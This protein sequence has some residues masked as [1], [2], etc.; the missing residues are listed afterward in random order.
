M[1]IQTFKHP[2]DLDTLDKGSTVLADAI[3]SAYGVKRG[4]KEF[5][6]AALRMQDFIRNGLAARG[7]TVTM[8]MDGDTIRILTD[9]EAVK[10]NR[11]AIKRHARGMRRTHGRQLGSDRSQMSEST[12]AEH[13]RDVEV[14]GRVIGA[15]AKE[16]R[17]RVAATPVQRATPLPP[18]SDKG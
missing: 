5:Q 7:Q 11:E 2:I 16:F 4:T 18:G 13:D 10:Y 12:K 1:D 17:R 14:S 6:F 15:M 9:E 3:E 8:T